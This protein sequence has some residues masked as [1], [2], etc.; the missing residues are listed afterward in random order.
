MSDQTI[1]V[2]GVSIEVEVMQQSPSPARRRIVSDRP[3]PVADWPWTLEEIA[4]QAQQIFDKN[5]CRSTR[6]DVTWAINRAGFGAMT[7]DDAPYYRAVPTAAEARELRRAAI[8]EA[9]D[10]LV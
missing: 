1:T 3:M 8:A 5:G 2:G 9:S 4:N 7:T 6:A 10:G